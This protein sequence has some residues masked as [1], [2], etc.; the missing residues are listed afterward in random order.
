M[1]AVNEPAEAFLRMPPLGRGRVDEARAELL[2]RWI[3]SL[4]AR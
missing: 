1:C 4:E 2:G 3:A